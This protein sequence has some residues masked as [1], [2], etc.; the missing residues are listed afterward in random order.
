VHLTPLTLPEFNYGS[1]HART[2]TSGISFG[3][4]SIPLIIAK[5]TILL[6]PSNVYRVKSVV[7]SVVGGLMRVFRRKDN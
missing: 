4:N 6:S 7:S 2:F 5:S 3:V 1:L